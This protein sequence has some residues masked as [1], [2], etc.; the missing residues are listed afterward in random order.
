MRKYFLLATVA[1]FAATNANAAGT[2]T[3]N[4]G[5]DAQLQFAA[6]YECSN[7]SFGTITVNSSKVLS[8]E[9][10]VTFTVPAQVN[11]EATGLSEN[12]SAVDNEVA[13]ICEGIVNAN[14]EDWFEDADFAS[15]T[16]KIK[17][18]ANKEATV[19]LT[20]S[21][22]YVG[23]TVSFPIPNNTVATL[24]DWAGAYTGEIVINHTY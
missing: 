17:N 8:T 22:N 13:G 9:K 5:A 2:N 14:G 18:P 1:L 7:L 3:A 4:L 6:E 15:D 21:G 23:G 11:A 10:P 16:I 24:T 12:I 20:K 19:T